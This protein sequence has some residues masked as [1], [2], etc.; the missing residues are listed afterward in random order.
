MPG[1]GM[2]KKEAAIVVCLVALLLV[3]SS[4]AVL[5]LQDESELRSSKAEVSAL[6]SELTQVQTE[7]S[8]WSQQAASDQGNLSSLQQ[9]VTSLQW[10]ILNL[11]GGFPFP[12]PSGSYT[13]V[14]LTGDIALAVCAAFRSPCLQYP[15]FNAKAYSSGNDTIYVVVVYFNNVPKTLEISSSNSSKFCITPPFPWTTMCP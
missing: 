1:L 2:G 13:N 7:L 5:F 11:T 10:Q 9:L 6:Q 4:F 12:A 8:F 14:T 3:S 15:S